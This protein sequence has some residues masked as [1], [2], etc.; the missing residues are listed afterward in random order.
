MSLRLVRRR[1]LGALPSRVTTLYFKRG[2][3]CP[4]TPRCLWEADLRI[5]VLE[6]LAATSV[7]TC[8]QSLAGEGLA[9]L[10]T[11]SSDLARIDGIEP[12]VAVHAEL[13]QAQW[14]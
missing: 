13:A 14:G 9:M 4:I 2:V 12:W 8:E 1:R 3:Y 6:H 10:W 7:S 5:L 11:I